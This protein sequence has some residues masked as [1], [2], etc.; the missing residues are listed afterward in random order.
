[1]AALFAD[2]DGD[3]KTDLFVTN[4]TQANHFFRGLGRGRFHEEGLEAGVALNGMGMAEGSMGVDAA[5]VDGDG[6]LDLVHANFRHEGTRLYRNLGGGRFQDISTGSYVG[7]NTLRFVGWGVVLADFDDDGWPDLFQANGHVYPNVTDSDYAQPPLF[8]RNRG[9]GTFEPA[10]APWGPDLEKAAA[11]G[12]SVAAGDLDGDGDLDLVV[13]TMDGPLR[14]LIN[15]GTRVNHSVELRLIG[16][17]PGRDALGAWAEIEAGGRTHRGQVRSGGSF[18]AAPDMAL[19]FGLGGAGTLTR[20][21]VHWADGTRHAFENLPADAR[22][23]IRQDDGR[24]IT[25]PFRSARLDRT[26]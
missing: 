24:L 23:T 13:T 18:L 4:D 22:H 14:V 15:E 21:T 11:G 10:T 19:H 16:K 25:A 2:W 3:G 26:L 17:A 8:L 1:M 20:L 9:D 5:D 12:R 6:L 7:V